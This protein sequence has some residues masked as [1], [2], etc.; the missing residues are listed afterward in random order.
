M[1]RFRRRRTGV[2]TKPASAFA[3]GEGA[4]GKSLQWEYIFDQPV[5][6]PISTAIASNVRTTG[7]IQTRIVSLI[8]VNVTQGVVTLERIRG[9]LE[10]YF[11][12][13]ELI[14]DFDNWFVHMQI[15]IVPARNGVMAAIQ[16][17]SPGN[18]ADQ[19]SNKIV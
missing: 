14:A 6:V 8:P 10:I 12:E 15:Q 16:A 13:A 19:E 2:G 7:T 4:R 9:H 5:P 11:N 1:A 18:A 17:L 3:G